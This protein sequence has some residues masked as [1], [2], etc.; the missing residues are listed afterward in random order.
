MLSFIIDTSTDYNLIALANEEGILAE[1]SLPPSSQ[2]SRF[3]ALSINTLLTEHSMTFQDLHWIGIGIG[4]GSFTG[5]RC[6]VM[7]AKSLGYGLN[8]PLLPFCSLALFIPQQEGPFNILSD[9][10]SGMFYSLK[11]EKKGKHLRLNA[12]TLVQGKQE[13]IFPMK[14]NLSLLHSYLYAQAKEKKFMSPIEVN[15]LYLKSP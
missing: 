11:G 3:L 2:P 15:V 4:P 6:G 7:I 10:K 12:P 9:A 14:C 1:R 8:V 5:T 13:C